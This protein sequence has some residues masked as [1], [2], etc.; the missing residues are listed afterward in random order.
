MPHHQAYGF[1]SFTRKRVLRLKT[2]EDIAKCMGRARADALDLE[3]QDLE[4]DHMPTGAIDL[5]STETFNV[6]VHL[7]VTPNILTS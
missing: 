1:N 3:E 4:G 7:W 6:S 5:R 2:R